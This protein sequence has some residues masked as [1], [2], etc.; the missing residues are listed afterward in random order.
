MAWSIFGNTF[1][2]IYAPQNVFIQPTLKDLCL[3]VSEID[4]LLRKWVAILYNVLQ[5]GGCNFMIYRQYVSEIYAP[6]NLY[7]ESTLKVL[8][9]L[10]S[11]IDV[12]L[13]KWPPFFKMASKMAD[14][15]A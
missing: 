4:V 3:L 1:S 14:T 6:Q 8:R 15:M 2:E 10:V 12:L 11:K 13:W 5:N 9:L 7:I